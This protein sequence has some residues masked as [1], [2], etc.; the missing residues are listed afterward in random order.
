[1]SDDTTRSRRDFLRLGARTTALGGVVVGGYALTPLSGRQNLQAR[2]NDAADCDTCTG[3][4]TVWQLDPA[5][6]VAC[7]RCQ[8]HCVRAESADKC[9]QAFHMCG[10]CRI[11]PGFFETPSHS[12]HEAAENQLCPTGAVLRRFVEDPYYEYTIDRDLCIACGRCVKGCE[13]YGNGSLFLQVDHG[14]CLDCNRCSIA[15]ACPSQ[16]FSRVP[17]LRPYLLKGR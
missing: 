10:Y 17:L 7:G 2:C 1:M 12:L 11:C 14:L 9:V 15:A 8:T 4:G 5:L 6:C 16:A 3:C 13:A